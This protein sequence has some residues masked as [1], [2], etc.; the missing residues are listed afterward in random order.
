M[1]VLYFINI[2]VYNTFNNKIDITSKFNL[3]SSLKCSIDFSKLVMVSLE[4]KVRLTKF[5]SKLY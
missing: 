2:N 1:I 4:R 3:Y 5:L